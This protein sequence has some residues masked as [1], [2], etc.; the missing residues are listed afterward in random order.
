[1]KR[2]NFWDVRPKTP[3]IVPKAHSS[4][5]G[6]TGTGQESP[7]VPQNNDHGENLGRDLSLGGAVLLGLGAK[8]VLL[9]ALALSHPL[10]L[11][12]TVPTTL[13]TGRRYLHSLWDAAMGKG[14]LNT[15][16]LAGTATVVSLVSG[17]SVA[18]LAGVGVL[19][20]GKYLTRGSNGDQDETGW[21]ALS[22]DSLVAKYAAPASLVLGGLIFASDLIRLM[23]SAAFSLAI[24]NQLITYLRTAPYAPLFYMAAYIVR[25][26]LLPPALYTIAGGMVFGPVKGLLYSLVGMNALAMVS[27][28]IARYLGER[29]VLNQGP[30]QETLQRYVEP[31]RQKPFESVLMMRLLYLPYDVVNYLAGALQLSWQPF[32]L[33]TLLGSLPGTISF[34][35]L[36]ASIEGNVITAIPRLNPSTL[37]ASGIILVSSLALSRYL[38][39][40][41]EDESVA[42]E[43]GLA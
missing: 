16:A 38:N 5:N 40:E 8:Q 23:P 22:L 28:G 31:M 35:L 2:K 21:Q 3:Y 29:V 1:M 15:E 36:G 27:Y 32:L 33:A 12:V 39:E 25:P 10:L 9:P 41:Q 6:G 30:K 7:L 14:A 17:G 20:L 37:A 19:N 13:F 26:A 4:G 42:G 11:A 18:A 34:V 43:L 24:T